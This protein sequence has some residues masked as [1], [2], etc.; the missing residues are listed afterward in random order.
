MSLP[1][2]KFRI[3]G[4]DE[5]T[6]S[7]RNL[8]SQLSSLGQQIQQ[9]GIETEKASQKASVLGDIAKNALGYMLGI[10]GT[11]A[12]RATMAAA[13]E[14]SQAFIQYEAAIIR[15]VSATNVYGEEASKLQSRLTQTAEAQTDLGYSAREATAGLE[16]L[17][18]AGMSGEQAAEALRSALSLARLES[19]DT[20]SASN[21]LVQILT[22]FHKAATDSAEA[23][24]SLS[25]AAD[26]G[27]GTATDYAQGLAN[28]GASAANM[29][30]SL[31]ETLAAL[32]QLDKTYG[33]AIESGTFLNMMFRNMTE[34]SEKLGINIYNADGSMRSLDEIIGQIRTKVQAFGDDQA[35]INEY[36][37]VFDVRAQRA[38]IG[39]INYDGSIS[40]TMATMDQARTVE[41]KLGMTMDTTAGK[42]AELTA[43]Q[44]N[45]S[46]QFGQMTSQAELAWK[47]FALGLGP[48]G[49]VVNALGP[50]MLQGAI[51]ALMMNL[52]QLASALG[53]VTIG[54]TTL[55]A[56]VSA[57]AVP[58]A[59]AISVGAG[60]VLV[61][62][63]IGDWATAA[64][65]SVEHT[66]EEIARASNMMDDYTESLID[67]SKSAMMPAIETQ[68]DL[69]EAMHDAGDAATDMSETVD[70][71]FTNVDEA[72]KDAVENVNES[73]E[74]G[75]IN[76][77]QSNLEAFKN[78]V[79]GKNVG[80]TDSFADSWDNV[81]SDTNS[82]IQQGLLGQAQNNIEAFANC[83][84]GKQAK[85]VDDINGYLN[86]LQDQYD[87]NIKKINDLTAKGLDKE[88]A[89][90]A[91][92]NQEILAKMQQ[93]QAWKEQL[94][95]PGI[96]PL[97]V[98]VSGVSQAQATL[99]SLTSAPTIEQL[100]AAGYIKMQGGGIVEKPTLAVLGEKGPEAVVPLG[101]NK[102]LT[103]RG[104]MMR[105]GDNYTINVVV[106]NVN[107]LDD[108]IQLK[109]LMRIVMGEVE[110]EYAF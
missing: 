7:F 108:P 25:R 70:A 81:V 96:I 103:G 93:L 26:A 100:Q 49:A 58:F 109:K 3:I 61:L 69:S 8:G 33:S 84:V 24:T 28:C 37:S 19:I 11:Q 50:S 5:F 92:Q 48:I 14:A 41:D 106:P 52:P 87:E 97:T 46:Y 43:Q 67:A 64:Y 6:S 56:A 29:G 99:S 71:A 68:D 15:V 95:K 54:A 17:V 65:Y 27:I 34:S 16:A 94:I 40:D 51:M 13:S 36:L 4:V 74:S 86:K 18:K 44:E 78:C 105:G 22:M 9:F 83:V 88:A 1:D 90:Y 21:M 60:L 76:K 42:M 75:L 32:V 30:L 79:E 66:D 35:A 77:A 38:V 45:V 82:L 72:V 10:I 59:T 80:L 53:S 23:L 101:R 89:L 57:L 39:L 102:I 62:K 85:M 20:A 2:L 98:T 91:A 31:D 63:G 107:S 55:G 104:E 12:I 47:Q 73:V 110:R